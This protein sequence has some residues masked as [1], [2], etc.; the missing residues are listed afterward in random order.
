M[1]IFKKKNVHLILPQLGPDH[2]ILHR[3][4]VPEAGDLEE[5]GEVVDH[6]EGCRRR[7]EPPLDAGDVTER[8]DD[9]EEALERHRHR[10]QHRPD[11]GIQ[12]DNILISLLT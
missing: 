5:L 3:L 8:K 10:R 6:R 11:P 12:K 9:G 2:D 7:N 4:R 1:P